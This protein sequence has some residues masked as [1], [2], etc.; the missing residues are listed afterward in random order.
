MSIQDACFC[1]L[2]CQSLKQRLTPVYTII[3]HKCWAMEC[4]IQLESFRFFNIKSNLFFVVLFTDILL[5]H[6]LIGNVKYFLQRVQKVFKGRVVV[7]GW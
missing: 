2:C 1:F 6:I 3:L 7:L 5:Y 4:Y